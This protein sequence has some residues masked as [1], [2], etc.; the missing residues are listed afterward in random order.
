MKVEELKKKYKQVCKL[1]DGN[2]MVSTKSQ[3]EVE[4]VL[5]DAHTNIDEVYGMEGKW[6]LVD[7][8]GNL[9]IEP[10]YLYPSIECGDNY[11]VML[12][13]QYKKIHGK[14][15]VL[16]IKHG[17]LDK[18]GNVVIP[19]QYLYM[20]AMDNTGKYFRV[21]ED[22]TYQSGVLNQNNQVVVPFQYDYI[23]AS[24]DLELM[25]KTKY[26]NIYPDNIYQV[27]ISN[28]DVYGIYDLTLNKEIIKPKYA[29]LKI[30]SYN[31]FLIGE[32]YDSC[33]TLIDEKELILK[34]DIRTS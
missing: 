3:K 4:E 21:V 6:G 34:E 7:K 22:K 25:L 30:I 9:I 5:Y 26:G 11:Q 31:R 14:K 18:K 23:K 20:E 24:P 33:Y 27:K 8:E 13:H 17:L 1:E 32:D 12:P 10:K 15:R 2:Y 19:I 29:Y 28:H 16:T